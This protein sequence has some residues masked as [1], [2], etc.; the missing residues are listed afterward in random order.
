MTKKIIIVGATSGIGMAVAQLFIEAGWQIGIAGRREDKLIKI[1]SCAPSQVI[2]RVIDICKEDA[3][4]RLLDLIRQMDGLDYYF[5]ASGI[6]KQNS[7][8]ELPIEIATTETN[9]T[10]F[11]R[12]VDTAFNYFKENG[13]G[14]I[15]VISSIAGTKGL[16]AA[17]AY[18]ATKRFNNAYIQCL[19]QLAHIQKYPITFTDIK[20]GFVDTAILNPEKNYP[21]MMKVPEVAQSIF[22]ALIKKKR[23]KI[24]DWR[25]AILVFFW[26]CIPDRLWERLRIS[27]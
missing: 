1:A 6:G 14:H 23:K 24:I 3:S 20:P 8:L 25:F 26:K 17:P 10:G 22:K 5:H 19:A 9:V 12:M 27:N 18:S 11:V 7:I 21:M 13:G 4:E 15:G 16:G 2:Y